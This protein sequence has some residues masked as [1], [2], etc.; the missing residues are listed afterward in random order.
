M[1]VRTSRIPRRATRGRA[2]F[3]LVLILTLVLSGLGLAFGP[4]ALAMYDRYQATRPQTE[5]RNGLWT[6]VATSPVRSVHAVLEDT[7]N[8]LL[9]AGTGNNGSLAGK[10]VTNLPQTD[11]RAAIFDPR[12]M[13]FVSLSAFWDVFCGGHVILP[14]GNILVSGGTRQYELIGGRNKIISQFEG[15]R[16]SGIF[17]VRTNTWIKTSPLHRARWYP[18]LVRA[19]QPNTVIAVSGLDQNGNIDPGI[20]EE[21]HQKTLKW[22]VDKIPLRL[23]PTYPALF[24]TAWKDWLFWSG[25]NAGYGPQSITGARHPGLWNFQT[26]QFVPIDGLS[27]P[28]DNETAGTILLPPAQKQTFMFF[29]GGGAGNVPAITART[30]VVNLGS[31]NP[32][33]VRGP[34]LDHAKRYPLGTILPDDTVLIAGGSGRYRADDILS[35]EIYNPAT[36]AMREVASPEVGR[37]YHGEA[38]L[39]NSGAVFYFGSNPLRNNSFEMRVE[40][41]Q[42]PYFFEGLRPA[43]TSS[44]AS[45]VLGSTIRVHVRYSSNSPITKIRLI[46]PSAYTHVTDTSQRSVAAK[47]LSQKDG[48]L[49]IQLPANPNLLI[50]GYY[51]LFAVNARGL[52]SVA[53]WIHIVTNA[54]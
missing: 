33:Y 42:P 26:G 34:D 19:G 9:M 30:A 47:I 41:Y 15:V 39:V 14:D 32:H 11:Y 45:A 21:F 44:P 53:P 22:V 52:P 54:R 6:I 17:D 1:P 51:M 48:W 40:E 27:Q 12:T 24:Q 18:T 28:L 50:P 43:I 38:I 23:F 25:A 16:N 2:I 3:N 36:N 29:G 5:A 49:T 35:A 20:T 4:R 10:V 8:I 31:N 13:S 46:A 37:D 7:G